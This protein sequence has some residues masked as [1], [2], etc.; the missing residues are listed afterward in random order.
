MKAAACLLIL[1]AAFM[2]C[3][4]PLRGNPD[5][6]GPSATSAETASAVSQALMDAGIPGWE[7]IDIRVTQGQVVLRGP[8]ESEALEKRIVELASQVKG[9]SQLRSEL[10]LPGA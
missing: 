8:V 10:R 3:S 7:A 9:V 5:P 2:A 4:V 6:S 1:L